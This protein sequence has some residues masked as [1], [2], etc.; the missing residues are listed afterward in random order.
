MKRK[1][2][3]DSIKKCVNNYDKLKEDIL[4]YIENCILFNKETRHYISNMWFDFKDNEIIVELCT[5]NFLEADSCE[6]YELSLND[7]IKWSVK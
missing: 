1:W 4:V 2:N 3:I 5:D 7:F 6:T